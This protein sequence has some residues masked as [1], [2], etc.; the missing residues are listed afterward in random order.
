MLYRVRIFTG[1][2]FKKWWQSLDKC[3][4]T[5]L[6]VL[7]ALGVAT[8]FLVP[9]SNYTRLNPMD[10]QII[11]RQFLLF[12]FIG[13][14]AFFCA[15]MLS[16][17]WVNRVC[18][19]GAICLFFVL[20]LL[21]F[22][23]IEINGATRWL[24]IGGNSVQP[25]EFAKPIFAVVSAWF[26]CARFY[27]QNIPATAMSFCLCLIFASLF[28]IQPD[29]GQTVLLISIWG[30]QL[31]VA[32]ARLRMILLLILL[33]FLVIILMYVFF[34]HVSTR[35]QGF[36][37]KGNADTY[38][39]DK[40]QEAFQSGGFT[41]QGLGSGQVTNN[42]PDVH[43]D[44]IFAVY[45]E[46]FGA[47]G[48]LGTV[49]VLILFVGI[50]AR[51][52]ILTLNRKDIFCMIA[53]VGICIQFSVQTAINIASTTGLIPPKG[54]TLP[55]ISMGGSSYVATAGALGFFMALSRRRK[56]KA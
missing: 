32:G 9:S 46:K 7:F 2:S 8:S 35:I 49:I 33:L 55:L 6:A 24:M 42:L 44:F 47:F 28:L 5:L 11:K 34:P 54:M 48:A 12:S 29:L 16:V 40:A 15:S 27:T 18:V 43:T 56:Y 20:A 25:S 21:P 1:F 45:A 22:M 4:L 51:M 41:G 13:I 17:K 26:F 14:C 52:L 23:G 36:F 39:S 30:A 50:I 31:L 38:Q 19:L 10:G 53:M 37:G 3:L